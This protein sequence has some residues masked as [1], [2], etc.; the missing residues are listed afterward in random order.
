MRITLCR[1]DTGT[2]IATLARSRWLPEHRALTVVAQSTDR[3]SGATALSLM[4]ALGKDLLRGGGRTVRLAEHRPQARAWLVGHQIE[5]VAVL[6]AQTLDS[7]NLTWTLDLCQDAAEVVLISD[8]GTHARLQE[9]ACRAVRAL[10]TAPDVR[11]VAMDDLP[12][13]QRPGAHPQA[14]PAAYRRPRRS[15]DCD[16]SPL[17]PAHDLPQGDF[18]TWRGDARR[19]LDEASFAHVDEAY[20]RAYV[21]A[22]AWP[23][24]DP[25]DTRT[26]L[27]SILSGAATAAQQIAMLRAVQAAAFTRGRL[28]R[29]NMDRVLNTVEGPDM[30]GQVQASHWD[31]LNAFVRTDHAASCALYLLGHPITELTTLR[32]SDV[33][34]R[35]T[36]DNAH[37]GDVYLRAH[38]AYRRHQGATPEDGYLKTCL[39]QPVLRRARDQLGLP[40]TRKQ[41]TVSTPRT[42]A[43]LPSLSLSLADLR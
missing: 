36:P 34:T 7:R 29:V 32:L 3:T 6:S 16:P 27:E 11:D 10:G 31:A 33:S 19:T 30:V 5:T 14:G 24:E 20:R 22:R 37:P 2:Q 42:N 23:F 21:A 40:I 35:L 8:P 38:L 13:S 28:L 18:L 4:L 1:T 9:V 17:V 12:L 15:E 25:Y 41:L 43:L 39:P 26:R